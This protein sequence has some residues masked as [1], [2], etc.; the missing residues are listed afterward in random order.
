MAIELP[1]RC[2]ASATLF[3]L[4]PHPQPSLVRIGRF[5]TL[6]SR[7]RYQKT[8]KLR[9]GLKDDAFTFIPLIKQ[10]DDIGRKEY[11]LQHFD[12]PWTLCA[13]REN[14]GQKLTGTGLRASATFKSVHP[15]ANATVPAL[16]RTMTL[17]PFLSRDHEDPKRGV[18]RL[19]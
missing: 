18:R 17:E 8:R 3:P 6:Q 10:T 1:E 16:P 19:A 4:S 5:H 11:T 7:G 2:N 12:R 9:V 14:K 13:A 15:R